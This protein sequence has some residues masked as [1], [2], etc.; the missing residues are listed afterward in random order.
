MEGYEVNEN[1]E[2]YESYG[3]DFRKIG[4]IT[5]EYKFH[6]SYFGLPIYF[7]YN[8]GKLGIKGGIQA[9]F[10]ITTS[11]H[12]RS[13]GELYD[14]PFD[15]GGKWRPL[16]LS[17]MDSGPKFGIDY[18]LI[19]SLRLRMDYYH[20]MTDIAVGRFDSVR[21]NRQLGIGINYIFGKVDDVDK[22]ERVF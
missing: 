12:F 7:R 22:D 17:D 13:Y 6:T 8:F 5:E 9:L 20:G 2:F 19:P 16:E 14:V 4:F 10:L 21:K 15:S 3:E 1:I 11:T 18:Q